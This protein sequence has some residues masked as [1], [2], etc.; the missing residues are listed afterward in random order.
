[1]EGYVGGRVWAELFAEAGSCWLSLTVLFPEELG[2][3]LKVKKAG[4]FWESEERLRCAN[5]QLRLRSVGEEQWMR[6]DGE[7]CGASPEAGTR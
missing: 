5:L 2:Y 1:M 3:G 7:N 6:W 4:R